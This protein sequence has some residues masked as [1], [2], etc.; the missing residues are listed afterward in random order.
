MRS[1]RRP[2][3]AVARALVVG[4]LLVPITAAPAVAEP[5]GSGGPKTLTVGT[6]SAVDSL[7]PFLAIRA[8]P[9]GLF[10][11]MYDF[12]TNYDPKDGHVVPALAESWSA[13]P[14]KLTW[15]YKIRSGST[16]S[17]GKPVTARDAA[18]TFNLIKGNKD[19]GKGSGSYVKNFKTVTA[20]D[21]RTLVIELTKPQATM[22]ALDVPIVP[23][24]VWT[25]KVPE[26]GKFNN[27]TQ[28]PIIGDGPFQLTDYKKSEYIE[29]TAN[30]NYWRGAPKFDKIVYRYFKDADAEVEALKKGEI[31]LVSDML[32]AQYESLRGNGDVSLNK[33][34]GKRFYALAINPGPTTTGGQA[35]G[36]A[37]P[38]LKDQKVRHALARAI[39]T[40]AL[41]QKTLGGYGSPGGGYLPPIWTTNHWDPD[42]STKLTFDLAAANKL[43]DEAGY[44]KGAGGMRTTPDGKPF[45]LRVL[46][47][48]SRAADTQNSTFMKEWYKQIGVDL[49]PSIVES[50]TQSATLQA[51]NYDL[52]F[53]SW[54]TNPDPDYVL[55]LHTC[56]ARPATAGAAF[57]GDNFVCVPAYDEIYNKQY[58]EYD[59]AARTALIKQAQQQL[60]TDAYIN[61]LYYP[62]VLEAFRK[63]TV[64]SMQKM[65]GENG[66]YMNQDGYWSFW[67]A[68]P[69]SASEK[70]DDGGGATVPILIAVAVLLVAAAVGFVLVRRRRGTADERE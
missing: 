17:D 13:S 65:P 38:A 40:N 19:A 55:S 8:L 24:H 56:G 4:L 12:L 60:Y 64:A 27:D 35:F 52:A 21:D 18:W 34:Q 39:D 15:T 11:Q 41:V 59:T 16:W 30:K 68:V 42:G 66:T 23:E 33:G 53:T 51:G 67:S 44:A 45:S 7:S 14:D 43:L 58:A 28:F 36:D 25:S 48:T 5:A 2:A 20:P 69:T 31:D 49:V 26:I 37:N 29:L 1:T 57:P 10:R 9:T 46:G 62:N 54:Q 50:G 61:V 70:D 22:L 3:H 32:P 6:I 63:G 47:V